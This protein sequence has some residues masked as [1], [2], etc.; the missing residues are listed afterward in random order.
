MDPN[1]L[2]LA[3]DEFNA[4]MLR[5]VMGATGQPGETAQD[6]QT[7]CGA[8]V[9]I[10]RSFEAANPMEAMIAC[11][12]ISLRFMLDAA[13]RDASAADLP[14]PLL[15]RMRASAM[16]ISKI[17]HL[18]MTSF[19]SLHTRNEARA[20]ELQQHASQPEP[21][22]RPVNPQ[23]PAPELPPARP[24]QL[25]PIAAEAAN[26]TLPFVAATTASPDRSTLGLPNQPAQSWKHA[27]LSSVALAQAVAA[28]GRLTGATSPPG[29]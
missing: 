12:C 28:N 15:L 2:M 4:H 29:S 6:V 1:C 27:L 18:W 8:V 23:P 3:Q 7:R 24:E 16:A 19:A 10:F 11:H 20:V 22:A 14:P 25:R 17:L 21:V 26:A 9:E 5:G 13:M